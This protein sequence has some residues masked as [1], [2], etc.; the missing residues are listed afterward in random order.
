MPTADYE[1]KVESVF[2]MIEESDAIHPDNADLL[3]AYR[4]DKELNGMSAATQQRNL[5]YLKI[6]AEHVEDTRFQD[7]DKENVKQLIEWIHDRDLADATV[8]TYKKA[9]RQFWTWMNDG[10]TPD[11][12]DWMKISSGTSNDTLPQD[13]LTKEDIQEQVDAAKNP[14]DRAFIYLLYETGARIGELIDL[15]VGDIEDRTHGKKVT[16]SGKTGARRL[17]L[18][19]SV[20]YINKWLNEHPNPVKDAPLWCKIQQGGPTETV[21][22]G[23]VDDIAEIYGIGREMARRLSYVGVETGEDLARHSAEDLSHLI[24][25]K[26]GK[27]QRWLD[28]FDP[29]AGSGGLE[30]LGYRYIRDKILKTNMERAGID[31]PSN[32]HHYRHSRA[33]FLANEMT[34]AQLCKW[35][36]W[37]QGS[38]VPA[39]YVHLSG[40]D[41]DNAYDQMHGIVE[42]EED[43]EDPEVRKCDRC[44]EL[45]ESDA[46]YCMRCGFAVNQEKAEEVETKV[47]DAEA[48]VKDDYKDLD[49]ED[50]DAV[51]KVEVLDSLLDDPDVKE[52]LASRLDE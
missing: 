40:R 12:V 39:R 19:E 16:I 31:K 36:G 26:Q 48:D 38:D 20:P 41:I 28:Q 33:S 18:V 49:P 1:K 11:A 30:K 15:T 6:V 21:R 35:F 46:T 27:A 44:G 23:D 10:E 8:D 3:R 51:E 42:P 2:E 7:M 37:V 22:P 17:P 5:S 47:E 24:G 50:T 32:P 14:R 34:E 29:D 4:R 25:V 13:L 43:D 52:I 45:N 9:I